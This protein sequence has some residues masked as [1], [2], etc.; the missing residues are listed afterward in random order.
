MTP[1]EKITAVPLALTVPDG[2]ISS[3]K[4]ANG[5]ALSQSVAL[6]H[7]AIIG[8]GEVLYLNSTPQIVPSLSFSVSPSTEQVLQLNATLDF[9]VNDSCVTGLAKVFVDDNPTGTLMT[10]G[11]DARATISSSQQ[12]ILS[13]GLH[14]IDIKAWCEASGSGSVM[15]GQ[16]NVSYFLFSN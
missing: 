4:I 15:T 7:N 2:A 8:S 14:T 9:S 12:I 5:A 13:P 10:L 1:R 11:G 6:S 16:S 3:D